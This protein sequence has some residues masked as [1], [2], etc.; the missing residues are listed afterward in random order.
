MD[1]VRKYD[2]TKKDIISKHLEINIDD[3]AVYQLIKPDRWWEEAIPGVQ[4]ALTRYTIITEL[5]EMIGLGDQLD[6]IGKRQNLAIIGSISGEC[7]LGRI[8]T[9]KPTGIRRR[10]TNLEYKITMQR[11]FGTKLGVLREGSRKCTCGQAHMWGDYRGHHG[12]ICSTGNARNRRHNTVTELC[13]LFGKRANCPVLGEQS[14][15]YRDIEAP[16][17]RAPDFYLNPAPGGIVEAVDV[18]ITG[19]F[20]LER[21]LPKTIKKGAGAHLIEMKKWQKYGAWCRKS[22]AHFQGF[23]IEVY[24]RLGKGAMSWLKKIANHKVGGEEDREA[25]R[26]F[27]MQDWLSDLAAV[28][29]K[30]NAEMIMA[31]RHKDGEL[32]GETGKESPVQ[33]ERQHQNRLVYIEMAERRDREEQWERITESEPRNKEWGPLE[34]LIGQTIESIQAV[35]DRQPNVDMEEALDTQL[36]HEARVVRFS[37]EE[38]KKKEE[39]TRMESRSRYKIRDPKHL[40]GQERDET[41]ERTNQA[42]KGWRFWEVPVRDE[43]KWEGLCQ[44]YLQTHQWGEWVTMENE[45]WVGDESGFAQYE[46]KETK[47]ETRWINNYVREQES[48][49]DLDQDMDPSWSQKGWGGGVVLNDNQEYYLMINREGLRWG[50][51]REKEW[52]NGNLQRW[53]CMRKY[54]AWN[55]WISWK[56]PGRGHDQREDLPK[57]IIEWQW[58]M[59]MKEGEQGEGEEGGGTKTT[60]RSPSN[61]RTGKEKQEKGGQNKNDQRENSNNQERPSPK[62]QRQ[63][64]QEQEQIGQP[65]EEGDG[66]NCDNVAGDQGS[67]IIPD[68]KESLEKI[69]APPIYDNHVAGHARDKEGGTRKKMEKI[70][71]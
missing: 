31:H 43:T 64:E 39:S 67:G 58:R 65:V 71:K 61:K 1:R 2:A 41:E 52:L 48:G 23:G 28:L 6:T 49:P 5:G 62:Q 15:Q 66:T 50:Q 18:S 16:D 19:G 27:I 22:G 11:A 42:R 24:G 21:M 53:G 55:A 60:I 10:M 40:E 17:G 45:V 56:N 9:M 26:N 25:M 7:G 59:K 51:E 34:E 36:D 8:L 47:L 63:Q 30:C 12:V 20:M 4:K 29:A 69:E 68:K 3:H 13:K 35:Q 38:D 32:I 54:E 14:L 57:Q 44:K 37:W 33:K 46:N 70:T